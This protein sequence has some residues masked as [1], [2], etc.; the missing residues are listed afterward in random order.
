MS[1][2]SDAVIVFYIEYLDNAFMRLFLDRKHSL[3]SD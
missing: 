2:D 1:T 3:F